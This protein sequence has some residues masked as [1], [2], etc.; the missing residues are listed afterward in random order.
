[1][2]TPTGYEYAIFKALANDVQE[3][4]NRPERLGWRLVNLQPFQFSED[5]RHV[6]LYL[7][8]LERPLQP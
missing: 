1:M 5:G 6:E 3:F 7:M 8:V 2:T 4:M